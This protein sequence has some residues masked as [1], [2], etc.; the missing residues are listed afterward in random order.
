MPQPLH[1]DTASL[2]ASAGRLD[3]VNE[4]TT[5]Q[6]SQNAAAL[7]GCQGGW[8]GSAFAAFEQVREAW[9]LAD[10]ARAEKLGDIALNLYRSADIYDH[11]DEASA[12]EID[13]TM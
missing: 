1:V 5:T 13:T 12:A 3:V 10:A 11:R 7:A 2:R 9:E 6:L 4:S 8:A